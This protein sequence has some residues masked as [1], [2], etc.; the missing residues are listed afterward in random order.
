MLF[1]F[2]VYYQ[3]LWTLFWHN[4]RTIFP[5]R[6]FCR[7]NSKLS[8]RLKSRKKR[9][10]SNGS[11]QQVQYR[12]ELE[13]YPRFA[14]PESEWAKLRLPPKRMTKKK[15]KKKRVRKSVEH[16]TGKSKW[17]KTP[18]TEAI[19]GSNDRFSLFDFSRE[20]SCD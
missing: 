17:I 14:V 13:T 7:N 3:V 8:A 15:K 4:F 2:F 5:F 18:W 19:S 9:D 1:A 10:D 16:I 20:T 6:N 11:F 12:H